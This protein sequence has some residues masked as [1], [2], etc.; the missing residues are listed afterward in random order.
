MLPPGDR[1]GQ[2]AGDSGF[3]PRQ[4]GERQK[5]SQI[6]QDRGRKYESDRRETGIK[7]GGHAG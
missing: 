6:E 5:E 2:H 7:P 3:C 4:R 1:C